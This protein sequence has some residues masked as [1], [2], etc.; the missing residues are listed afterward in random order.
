MV[1]SQKLGS[2]FGKVDG[3]DFAEVPMTVRRSR[4]RQAAGRGGLAIQAKTNS[5]G[6]EAVRHLVRYVPGRVTFTPD[7]LHRLYLFA[8]DS[9]KAT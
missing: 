8:S 1:E 9:A 4:P 2:R 6:L 3:A 7:S 5:V